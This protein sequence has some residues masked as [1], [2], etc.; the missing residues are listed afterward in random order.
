MP[1][2]LLCYNVCL[3]VG[4]LNG[5]HWVCVSTICPLNTI[6]VYS[7]LKTK[8][9]P[10]VIKQASALLQSPERS[11]TLCAISAQCQKGTSDCGLFTIATVKALCFGF[12][13]N[14]TKASCKNRIILRLKKW[15]HSLGMKQLPK[16]FT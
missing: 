14:G 12:V 1:N 2:T 15:S 5:N 9:C 13:P 3:R 10:H 6:H 8:I 4:V 7:S 11:I 16:E